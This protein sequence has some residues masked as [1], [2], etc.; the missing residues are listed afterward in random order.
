MT[1]V[2]KVKMKHPQAGVTCEGCG[3]YLESFAYRVKD[4]GGAV[5]VCPDCKDRVGELMNRAKYNRPCSHRCALCGY[6]VAPGDGIL[7]KVS[8]RFG[9]WATRLHHTTC[10][11]TLFRRKEVA[12]I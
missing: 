10:A 7:V 12:Q 1:S 2:R 4:S 9:E 6:R 5:W 8:P 3:T 11:T